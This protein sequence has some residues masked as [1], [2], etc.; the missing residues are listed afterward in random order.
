MEKQ[1]EQKS[2]E[3]ENCGNLVQKRG[4]LVFVW[5]SIKFQLN[6]YEIMEH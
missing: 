1:D 2:V 4:V 6:A 3:I 5:K